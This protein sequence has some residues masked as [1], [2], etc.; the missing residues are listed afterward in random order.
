MLII[1][2]YNTRES[3]KTCFKVEE[4]SNACDVQEIQ[5][6][7]SAYLAIKDIIVYE[8]AIEKVTETW[9][10]T[11]PYSEIERHGTEVLRKEND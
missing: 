5:E 3:R 1:Y 9:L 7:L 8:W 11:T 4:V 6:A 2:Y 10:M